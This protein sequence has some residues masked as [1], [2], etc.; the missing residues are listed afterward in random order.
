M[1]REAQVTAG[2]ETSHEKFLHRH[3]R[4]QQTVGCFFD[5]CFPHQADLRARSSLL[6][7]GR[8]R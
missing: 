6:D 1:I 4:N 8:I 2:A 7:L 5:A 3:L